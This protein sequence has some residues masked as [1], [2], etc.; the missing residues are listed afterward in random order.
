[1]YTSEQ[2][3]IAIIISTETV[4][5]YNPLLDDITAPENDFI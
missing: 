4:L 5:N 1:M 3:S 2:M